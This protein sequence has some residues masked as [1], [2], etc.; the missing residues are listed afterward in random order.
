MKVIL[1]KLRNRTD[2]IRFKTEANV[3]NVKNT[4]EGVEVRY[5]EKGVGRIAKAKVSCYGAQL[6]FAPNVIEGL[7]K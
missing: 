7:D 4:A 3:V 2:F 5:V 1:E 6:G